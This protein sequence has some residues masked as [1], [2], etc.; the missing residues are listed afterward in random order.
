MRFAT[1]ERNFDVALK[2][3]SKPKTLT[4]KLFLTKQKTF[5]INSQTK[6]DLR[7]I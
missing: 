1:F 2:L 7:V 6:F 5:E 3:T 4:K